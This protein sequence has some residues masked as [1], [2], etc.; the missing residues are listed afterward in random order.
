MIFGKKL[1]YSLTWC[2]THTYAIA[3]LFLGWEALFA[4]KYHPEQSH[5]WQKQLNSRSY[6]ASIFQ[7]KCN[8]LLQLRD[9]QVFTNNVSEPFRKKHSHIRTESLGDTF[10]LKPINL[11]S[12]RSRCW[13][14]FGGG[15]QPLTGPVRQPPRGLAR[16]AD[17]EDGPARGA[18]LPFV[19]H[20]ARRGSRRSWPIHLGN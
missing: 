6:S 1:L 18:G 20:S 8:S 19:F 15:G 17:T 10:I 3:F 11:L 13:N 5:W 4:D 7:I 14:G 12:E 9:W 16:A 2:D